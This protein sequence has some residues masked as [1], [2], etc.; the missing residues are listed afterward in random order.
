MRTARSIPLCRTGRAGRYRGTYVAPHTHACD[1]TEIVLEGS[2]EVTRKWR[3]AGDITI[4][5]GGTVYGPLI[6]GPEG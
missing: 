3:S 1:Y 2:E 5:K 4:V 6:A